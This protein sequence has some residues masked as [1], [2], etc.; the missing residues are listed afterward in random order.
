MKSLSLP[1][2]QV[3]VL[4]QKKWFHNSKTRTEFRESCL[5]QDKASFIHR[6]MVN[7]LIVY[8]LDTCSRGLNTKFTLSDCLFRAVKLT[9]NADS[10][11]FRYSDYGIGFIACSQILL[12]SD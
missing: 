8:E 10:D 9:K 12:P 7:L 4:L 5:K 1:L 2:H 3:I 11:K 6:N